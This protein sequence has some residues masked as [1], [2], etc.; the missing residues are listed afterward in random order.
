[1][2]DAL[3]SLM[4]ELEDLY[5]DVLS[6]DGYCAYSGSLFSFLFRFLDWSCGLQFLARPSTQRTTSRRPDLSLIRGMKSLRL[7][8]Y[9]GKYNRLMQLGNLSSIS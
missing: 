4:T 2:F 9:M 3:E 7:N 6:S 1:M 5:R 8:S